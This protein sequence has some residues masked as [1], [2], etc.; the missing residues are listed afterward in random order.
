MCIKPDVGWR[1]V[2]ISASYNMNLTSISHTCRLGIESK[3]QLYKV[4][5]AGSL[6]LI[7]SEALEFE[8]KNGSDISPESEDHVRS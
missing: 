1:I 7:K 6:L 3:I 5:D 4:Y 8:K 2:A